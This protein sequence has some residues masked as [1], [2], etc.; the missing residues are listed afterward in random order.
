MKPRGLDDANVRGSAAH[1][2]QADCGRRVRKTD[3]TRRGTDGMERQEIAIQ[4]CFV[5][6]AATWARDGLATLVAAL[7]AWLQEHRMTVGCKPFGNGLLSAPT[8]VEA[9][10][11]S[12]DWSP[13]H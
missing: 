9:R 6:G 4:R 13:R 5:T 3:V 11:A 8:P 10:V 1:R 7:F 12:V 2:L